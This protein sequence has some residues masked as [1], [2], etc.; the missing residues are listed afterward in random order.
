MRIS[1]T[2]FTRYRILPAIV[3]IKQQSPGAGAEILL[4][5]TVD[6]RANITPTGSRKL[7]IVQANLTLPDGTMIE[8]PFLNNTKDI[9]NITLEPDNITQRGTYNITFFANDSKNIKNT[10]KEFFVRKAYNII[11]LLNSSNTFL[12]DYVPEITANTSGVLNLTITAT[13]GRIKSL[14][15]KNHHESSTQSIL[16]I[17]P[18]SSENG[19][20][21]RISADT[22]AFNATE[23]SI[24]VNATGTSVFRCTD[25][26]FAEKQCAGGWEKKARVYP[27]QLYSIKLSSQDKFGYGEANNVVDILDSQGILKSFSSSV[28]Q[29]P[30]TTTNLT[31]YIPNHPIKRI[32]LKRVNN[33]ITNDL[34]IDTTGSPYTYEEIVQ[35]YAIDTGSLDFES[36]TI[37]IN[38][39]G[40]RLRKCTQWN[41]AE[42]KCEGSWQTIMTLTP[43][44]DYTL[45]I[46]PGDPAFQEINASDA[47]HLDTDKNIIENIFDEIEFEDG[48]YSPKIWYGEYARVQF[49]ENLSTGNYIDFVARAGG[50]G[51]YVNAYLMNTSTLVGT[52]SKLTNDFSKYYI[53]LI[54]PDNGSSSTFDLKTMSILPNATAY[55]EY[56][57]IHDQA[58]IISRVIQGSTTLTATET[59]VPLNTVIDTTN[60]ILF[61]SSR[62][63]YP[64]PSNGQVAGR[65]YNTTHLQFSRPAATSLI[66]HWYVAEFAH[67]TTVTRG[68]SQP[69]T[70]EALIATGRVI[71]TSSSFLIP[72]GYNNSGTTWGN[73]D[74]IRF[75]IANETHIGLYSIGATAVGDWADW[76]VVEFNGS[77]VQR[78]LIDMPSATRTLQVNITPITNLS[79]AFVIITHT[80]SGTINGANADILA[81]FV[82]TTQIEFTRGATGVYANISWEVVE[83]PEDNYVQ[84]G[85]TDFGVNVGELNITL[86]QINNTASVAFASSAPIAGL[87]SGNT[88]Y[89]TT[90]NPGPGMFTFNI[91]NSTNLRIQRSNISNISSIAWFVIQFAGPRYPLI[92]FSNISVV[93]TDIPDPVNASTNLTY[94][95]NITSNGNGT[96]YNVTVNDTYPQQVIYLTSSP[97]PISGT[98]NTWLLGNL[99]NGT[100]I[101]INITVL[102]LNVSHGTIINNTVN[103]SYNNHTGALLSVTASQSTTVSL[104]GNIGIILLAP[105]PGTTTDVFQN[106]TYNISANITC[107]GTTGGICGNISIFAR[108]NISRNASGQWFNSSFAY[109]REIT[110]TEPQ[111]RPQNN[112]HVLINL[113]IPS[114]RLSNENGTMLVCNNVQVP[115]DAYAIETS[116]GWVTHLEGLAEL[117][118]S[119]N[120]AKTCRL[121][122]DPVVNATEV[123]PTTTGT[124]YACRDAYSN[125]GT[126]ANITP[127]NAE[128]YGSYSNISL[129]GITCGPYNDY[130]T[131][132]IWCY[133]K[134]PR[135]GIIEFATSSDDGSELFINGTPAVNNK[136]CQAT[137]CRR[138]NS[139]S[140]AQSRYYP[141]RLTYDENAGINDL[142]AVYDPTSCTTGAP[143]GN[144]IDTECYP[145][146]GDSWTITSTISDEQL[147]TDEIFINISTINGA[148]PFYTTS[149]QPQYCTLSVGQSCQINWTVNATGP[150]NSL[151]KINVNATSNIST[152]NKNVT[153]NA[154][155]QIIRYNRAPNIT[156]VWLN[157]TN[158]FINDSDQNLTRHLIN[159]TDPDNDPVKNITDWRRNNASIALLN[160]PFEG[161]SNTTW[162]KD[163]SM[164]GNNGSVRD[165]TWSS[166]AGFDQKGAY[167]FNGINASINL[168]QPQSLNFTGFANFT[169]SA[170]INVASNS[171]THRPILCKGDYQYCLKPHTS[172]YFEFCVYDTT[173]KC[174]YSDSIPTPNTWYH[175]VAQTNGSSLHMFVNGILQAGTNTHTGISPDPYNVT[176]GW[177]GQLAGR[178][179]NGTIDEVQIWNRTLTPEQIR[180]LYNNRTDLIVSQEL[181]EG[182][183]WQACVTPNDIRTDGNTA[184]SNNLTIRPKPYILVNFTTPTPQNDTY[185]LNRTVQINFTITSTGS[186]AQ[187]VYNWN[188]TNYTVLNDS[189]RLMYNFQNLTALGENS[190]TIADLSRYGNTGTAYGGATWTG[191]GKYGGAYQLNGYNGYIDAGSDNSLNIIG[192]LTLL[193][194]INPAQLGRDQKIIARQNGT[195]GGY[196][197]GVFTNDKVE[198]EIRNAENGAT[199][200]RGVAGGT[201]LQT[202]NWYCVAGV[203]SQSGG[204]LATYVNGELDRNLSTTEILG[205]TTGSLII[206]REPFSSSY[207]FNGTIDEVQVWSKAMTPDELREQCMYSLQRLNLTAWYFQVNQSLNSTTELDFGDYNY[208]ACGTDFKGNTN[209]TLTQIIHIRPRNT[210][211]LTV[212]KTDS[213]DP[214]NV[215]SNLTYVIN[216]TSTGPGRAYNVTVNDTYP[217][218]VIYLASQ[219]TPLSGTNNTWLLGN[220]TANQSVLINI[221]VFTLNVTNGTI[222]NNTVNVSFNNETGTLINRSTTINTTVIAPVVAVFNFSNISVTKTDNPDPVNKSQNLTYHINVSSTGNG[223]A[224]NVTVNDTY[225]QQV[226]Y[227]TSS[228]APIS[229]TNNTW[230]LGNLTNGTSVLINITVLTL[231][232][233]NGTI[234]NNTVNISYTNETGTR[235]NTSTLYQR[236][237]P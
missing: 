198:M 214:V 67:N 133:F 22:T 169:I 209:C 74:F 65:I 201:V 14:L 127:S 104:H 57:R 3:H 16:R 30:D 110:F 205:P 28:E 77:T 17:E 165:A 117:N 203:Y 194:W 158:N 188:N 149:A 105:T 107:Y 166:S 4:N 86:E 95:I 232:V 121:Y 27:D 112:T 118:F 101:S 134:A 167:T 229:G 227:L 88:T 98:N 221:T 25:W 181:V 102:V 61:F 79:R 12:T 80:A 119:A 224:Y 217:L 52:S 50:P 192:E 218:Q 85:V 137:T 32:N 56:D 40:D 126:P 76:Q 24:I 83:L 174:I 130:F 136:Y 196:K 39:K 26:N 191:I 197:L 180:A 190:T 226:I 37:T 116:G 92:N 185:T 168:G 106:Y 45:T 219:P 179:F 146:Y 178:Y 41:M 176:I 207:Y 43:G 222:I 145:Y 142:Y 129:P 15:V 33:T 173:W 228:P 84:S 123:Q 11:D 139:T 96:A 109:S 10:T 64:D 51:V 122:Y 55:I 128:Y 18:L 93:K 71:N 162:T 143:T 202:N 230:L 94:Q 90:D 111:G 99:T 170:W 124:F 150:I 208:S 140:L 153:A 175:V 34:R 68:R 36:A 156:T 73:D 154:T 204:Y 199:L 187:F 72:G 29:N 91:T 54:I 144:Y 135:S 151:Y 20:I 70:T 206:G 23:V 63:D 81:R 87:S 49:V 82:N 125:C 213:P 164:L 78:G 13:S 148:T 163:Y 184:C 103:V 132:N 212:V 48:N 58:P 215:S 19:I 183:V 200:N 5:E 120:E 2:H 233:T 237:R 114:G 189:L 97:A 159:V 89:T 152:I 113:T 177:D 100:T 7:S 31:L 225:P 186:L 53:Q 115:F 21:S 235:L 231:N 216:I 236:N 171:G 182:E 47:W 141:M 193:A 60:S 66:V 69:T 75:R 172:N 161:G 8:L 138:G 195:S 59:F 42:Q 62:Q 6:I 44:E 147:P 160:M 211:N 1:V 108:Y 9:F 220:L 46:T 223:T 155:I 131:H 38:A 157:S 234:I 35:Q 210:S